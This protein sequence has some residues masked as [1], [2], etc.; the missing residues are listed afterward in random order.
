[1]RLFN[2]VVLLVITFCARAQVLPPIP[3]SEIRRIENTLASDEME[4]RRVYTPGIEK[5]AAF[6]SKEFEEAGLKPMPGAKNYNQFFSIIDPEKIKATADLD[7][8]ILR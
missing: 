3:E 4:G 7:G 2:T 6:I 1:M 5:A 8:A